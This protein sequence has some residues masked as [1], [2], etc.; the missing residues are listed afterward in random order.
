MIRGRPSAISANTL[1]TTVVDAPD[2][3]GNS[4]KNDKISALIPVRDIMMA[5]VFLDCNSV[6]IIYDK[7]VF[8]IEKPTK[9]G[10]KPAL[11]VKPTYK[12]FFGSQTNR[13][14][15]ETFQRN[16]SL[17][18]DVTPKTVSETVNL[19][20]DVS[21]GS[22]G[23]KV[24][25]QLQPDEAVFRPPI[26]PVTIPIKAEANKSILVDGS[27][28]KI[29]IKD[30]S[31]YFDI[32]ENERTVINSVLDP[33]W[34]PQNPYADPDDKLAV[35]KAKIEG[36]KL[37][38]DFWNNHF[39]NPFNI[40]DEILK[41]C[42]MNYFF[43]PMNKLLTAKQNGIFSRDWQSVTLREDKNKSLFVLFDRS[44][45]PQYTGKFQIFETQI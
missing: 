3:I 17:I 12:K 37:R 22:S 6:N 28:L 43:V 5:V 24:L 42:Q 4:E 29:T 15:A 30:E 11:V 16:R 10:Q 33:S 41:D 19:G 31:N 2:L 34:I 23:S 27:K 39:R 35:E 38:A 26:P 9:T 14:Q 44:K 20:C 21:P 36:A 18:E 7:D 40:F 32:I 8:E 45:T 13:N 25:S 1:D